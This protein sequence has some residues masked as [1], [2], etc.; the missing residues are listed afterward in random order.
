MGEPWRNSSRNSEK[1]REVPWGNSG[2]F[3]RAAL[4]RVVYLYN[5][6]YKIPW[7]NS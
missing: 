6:F 2:E 1:S 4:R 7:N 5:N 3:P